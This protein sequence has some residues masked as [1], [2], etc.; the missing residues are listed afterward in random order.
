MGSEL[1]KVDWTIVEQRESVCKCVGLVF[2]VMSA[3]FFGPL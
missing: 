2:P 1:P 3:G